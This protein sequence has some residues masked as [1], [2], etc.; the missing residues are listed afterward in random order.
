M[1]YE[2]YWI[3]CKKKIN[4]FFSS[5]FTAA[6]LPSPVRC[7]HLLH[8]YRLLRLKQQRPADT[9]PRGGAAGEPAEAD[10]EIQL[11]YSMFSIFCITPPS[12]VEENDCMP[13][14][15]FSVSPLCT[16]TLGFDNPNRV[17]AF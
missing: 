2:V 13:A 10:V 7:V 9:T 11:H 8:P 6:T 1:L 12:R 5:L 15:S 3:L 16:N 17:S 4:V 14:Y